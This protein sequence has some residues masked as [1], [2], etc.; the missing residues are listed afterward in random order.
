M[1]KFI[2]LLLFII[3][4]QFSYS[5]NYT[6]SG[7]VE[8]VN[9]GERIIGAY[10]VDNISKQT[11]Q[12]NNF[13]FYNLK[14]IKSKSAIQATFEGLTSKPIYLTLVKDTLIN[15]KI[16]SVRELNEVVITSSLYNRDVNAPLGITIIPIKQLTS[17]PALGE[18][19]LLKSI[20]N[21]PGIKGGVEGSAGIF[22]RGGGAGE[23]LFML[24]DVP[25]YNVSHFFGFFS[26]F[27]SSTVK[28][29]K[30]LKGCFPAQYGGRT[31]S[32][33]DVRSQDGNNQSIKGELSVGFV[34]TS[35]MLNGPLLSDKTTFMVSFRRS[36][37]DTYSDVLKK[38]DLIGND[39]PAYYFY[40]F[41]ARIT[42]TFSPKDRI[43]L[44]FYS[45]KDNIR[46]KN[47]ANIINETGLFN[48]N[49]NQTSGWSNFIGSLRWNHTF[50]N[51]IFANTTLAVSRYDYFTQDK[52]HSTNKDSVKGTIEKGYSA[53]Y[54]SSIYDIIVKTD[55]DYSVSNNHRLLFGG[56]NTFHTFNP[57]KNIYSMNDSELNEKTDTSFTNGLLHASEAYVYVEDEFKATQKLTINTG[58]RISGLI[59]ESKMSINPEPRISANYAMLPNLAFK[60]GY[61][62]MI[63]YM[64]LLSS[65]GLTMPTDI[66]VPALKGL[67]P[68]KSDQINAG[69]SYSWNQ[70]LL[71]SFEAYQKWLTNTTDYQNGA[72]LLTD[73]SPWYEKTTQGHGSSR[74]IE[75]SIEK[76]AGKLTGSINYT[77]SKA[78]R[79]YADLNNGQAFPFRYDRLHDF[80]IS[81]NYQLSKKWDVSALWVYGTGYPVTVYV[82]Q[83]L[84]LMRSSGQIFY[85]PS[86]NNCRLPDYHRLDLGFHYKKPTRRGEEIL[87]FDI[88]NAYN[89]LNPINVYYDPGNLRFV[90][91]YLLPV[92]P[93]V[94]YTLKF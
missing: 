78:D 35:L 70:K 14:N 72:S 58:L 5:Q 62:R 22:V 25:L 4:Y 40:D 39:F 15:V 92:I 87:S 7:Y 93:S 50:G 63:Q 30:L 54:N 60:T 38:F 81:A 32:V 84:T 24:D 88:Y 82:K 42:H 69:F 23:N 21:Q 51:N 76:Q 19:D 2:S 75:I 80:N 65:S 18:P 31:S 57:G 36:Y 1:L 29:L 55:F 83:Y 6:I 56:G 64:H 73:F 11:A 66:W 49:Q 44:S 89:R 68:L 77:L 17:M 26:T 3:A 74:G 37:F 45:G 90:Y 79:K 67:E 9:T 59:S 91:Y 61:S 8:D 10:V 41:N 33:I 34:S 71:F 13:G 46:G 12:T 27:N 53:N 85:Y 94:T 16:Q 28:D 86:L 43:S 52:Y 20:Q 47:G 48:D